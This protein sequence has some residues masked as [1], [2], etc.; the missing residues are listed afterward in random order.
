MNELTRWT[1]FY[2]IMCASSSTLI[3][4]LF[5]VITF[6]SNRRSEKDAG[7]IAT[8]L[9]P[10]VVYFFSILLTAAVLLFPNHTKLTAASCICAIGT[11]GL[12]YAVS[13]LSRK[14]ITMNFYKFS[15]QIFY[16]V[17]PLLMYC[18]FILGGTL[19]FYHTQLGLT[20]VAIGMV[21]LLSNNIRSSW[22]MAVFI[23]LKFKSPN[24]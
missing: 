14:G 22:A 11:L 17:I 19:L 18:L 10:T 5:V 16:I 23:D 24:A 9:T 2:T 21:L 7:K 6:A 15:D 12:I 13:L 8:Y 20:M 1:N 3:G 4:L